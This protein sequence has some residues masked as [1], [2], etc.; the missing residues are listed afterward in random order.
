MAQAQREKFATLAVVF[1]E[2]T[3]KLEARLTVVET[4]NLAGSKFTYDQVRAPVSKSLTL[5]INGRGP[6]IR[7][8]LLN[9]SLYRRIH[10]TSQSNYM[11]TQTFTPEIC[12]LDQ[13][14]TVFTFNTVSP[15]WQH[16]EYKWPSWQS[17]S[18]EKGYSDDWVAVT[19]RSVESIRIYGGRIPAYNLIMYGQHGYL[20]VPIQNETSWRCNLVGIDIMKRIC[21]RNLPKVTDPKMLRLSSATFSIP[22]LWVKYSGVRVPS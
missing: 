13:Y 1:G 9:L 6:Q 22:E 7:F 21:P 3:D 8:L 19:R 11:W 16:T 12:L 20:S 4:R 18:R 17:K 10:E 14:G 2:Y 5:A 15:S